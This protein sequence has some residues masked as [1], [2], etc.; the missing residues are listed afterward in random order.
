MT[1]PREAQAVFRLARDLVTNQGTVG[2]QGLMLKIAD[3]LTI[4]TTESKAAHAPHLKTSSNVL[5]VVRHSDIDCIVLSVV[6]IAG[7]QP[8]IATWIPGSWI[9][10]LRRAAATKSLANNIL[11][12][13]Q[14]SHK[15]VSKLK[16]MPRC[17]A[18][19]K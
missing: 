2:L 8:F 16:L 9:L 19:F 12:S 15:R 13:R 17:G 10:L 1:D 7:E 5:T 3:R 14:P 6:W 4:T 18:G 11:P